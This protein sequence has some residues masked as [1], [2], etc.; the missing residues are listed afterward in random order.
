MSAQMTSGGVP[1]RKVPPTSVRGAALRGVLARPGR[2]AVEAKGWLRA[3]K[4]LLLRRLQGDPF[5]PDTSVVV[6]DE[7]HERSLAS[8]LALMQKEK[9]TGMAGTRINYTVPGTISL[10]KA[11]ARAA[12]DMQ[13]PY[14]E[15]ML[16]LDPA[17]GAPELWYAMESASSELT[18]DFYKVAAD[19]KLTETGW[20]RGDDKQRI[21]LYLFFKTF[22]VSGIIT[23][24]CLL[25]AFPVAHLLAVLQ[26]IV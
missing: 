4:W 25:L 13:P 15:A 9:T 24:I 19:R 26:L 5:L 23:V 8:D 22:L 16:T 20:E 2:E 7:F 10:F 21:Y 14:K 11:G 3:H 12:K 1:E 17:W 18:T 6:F